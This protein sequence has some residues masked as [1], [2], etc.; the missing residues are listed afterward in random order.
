MCGRYSFT[1]SS[2]PAELVQPE[3]LAV[4]VSPRYNIAPSQLC[5]IIPQ[6][7]PE[8]IHLYQWGLL[9]HWAKDPK[10]GHKM[11][12]ARAETIA[13]KPAFRDAFQSSRCLVLADGFFEWKKTSTGK[14]PFRILLQSEEVFFF[15]GISNKWTSEMGEDRYTFSII[16]TEPNELMK[17]IHNR[18]PVI[19]TE[20]DKDLWLMDSSDAQI[21]LDLLQPFPSKYMKAYPVSPSLGNVKHD[22]PGLILPYEVP[23]TL[24]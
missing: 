22:H 15:A 16:T 2:L 9:P 7:D 13:E 12:N 18:M 21:H 20:Q 4:Q 23:P 3:G 17:G 1:K 8:R 11:I 5:P 24:F 19:L 6:D 10:I 14:Q